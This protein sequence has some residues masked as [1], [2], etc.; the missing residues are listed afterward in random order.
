MMETQRIAEMLDR[1]MVGDPWHG[2][3]VRKRLHDVTAADA[4]HLPPQGANSIW[5]LVLHMTGWAKEVTKRLGGRP[6]EEPADGDWP[7]MG[8]PTAPRWEKA[9][10]ELFEAHRDLA[11]AIRRLDDG[12]L[13]QP[14]VDFRDNAIGTGLSHYLTIHG[15]IHHTVYHAAQIAMLTRLNR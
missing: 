9:K 13:E 15:I 1:V 2:P 5:A 11:A 14:V 7:D 12:A 3:N 10:A 6:A 8:E 4:A